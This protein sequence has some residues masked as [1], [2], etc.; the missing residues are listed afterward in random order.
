M[1]KQ[2]LISLVAVLFALSVNTQAASLVMGKADGVG[3]Y[4]HDG[5]SYSW[6]GGW[7]SNAGAVDIVVTDDGTGMHVVSSTGLTYYS[8]DATSGALTKGGSFGWGGATAT[9]VAVSADGTVFAGGS[10]GFGAFSYSG[11]S[12]SNTAWFNNDTKDIAVDSNGHIHVAQTDGLSGWTYDLSTGLTNTAFDS[13]WAT[14]S[15]IAIDSTGMIHVGKSDGIGNLAYD[16]SSYTWGG[17][18]SGT[19]SGI[20]DIAIDAATGNI[21]AAQGDGVQ[22]VDSGYNLIGYGA[23]LG[24]I[25]AVCVDSDGEV[26]LGKSDGMLEVDIVS[27]I[28]PWGDVVWDGTSWYSGSQVTEIVEIVPEPTTMAMLGL[29]VVGLLRRK[30]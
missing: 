7:D 8:Y 9:S 19:A 4:N 12:Y 10:S 14:G 6:A 17:G 24:G 25:D 28:N 21:W 16:G 22:V 29:G 30:K 1:K 26:H 11:G 2:I 13:G 3:S 15:A 27:G 18:W 20:N 23:F 5:S